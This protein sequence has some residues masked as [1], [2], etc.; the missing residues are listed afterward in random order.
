MNIRFTPR[1]RTALPALVLL[2]CSQAGASLVTSRAALGGDDLL[3]WAQLPANT[4]AQAHS[5]TAPF[6]AISQLG[7]SAT[8]SNPPASGMWRVT[9]SGGSSAACN[10]GHQYAGNFA[11]CD[12]VLASANS[13]NADNRISILFASPIAGGG[14]QFADAASYGNFTA[15]LSA[16]DA[17]GA[18]L[19]TWSLGGTTNGAADDS[20]IF[21]GISRQQADIARLDFSASGFNRYFAINQVEI[22]RTAPVPDPD[23]NGV[24]EPS[25]W[26]LAALALPWMARRGLRR[27]HQAA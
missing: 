15:T 7:L 25:T 14:A 26:L 24:P 8:V 5:I 18:L 21:L 9:Q 10:L 27:T 20:A 2:A 11:P 12:A 16:F 4:L 17:A 23:P 6:A 22:D 13:A 19:E 1:P 3:D